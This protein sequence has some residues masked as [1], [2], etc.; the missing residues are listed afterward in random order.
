MPVALRQ[1]WDQKGG[2]TPPRALGG[3]GG[4]QWDLGGGRYSSRTKAEVC[5]EGRAGS[6]QATGLGEWRVDSRV[7]GWGTPE[8]LRQE[9]CQEGG[10]T[11]AH[12][13]DGG[14]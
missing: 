1:G 9:W 3:E 6:P 10:Q 5:W 13:G 14:Q 11:P 8:G 4:F 12:R 2:Q 7:T